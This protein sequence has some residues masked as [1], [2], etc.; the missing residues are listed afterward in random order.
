MS[1]SIDHPLASCSD[2]G[3]PD[4][5]GY[6]LSYEISRH[7]LSTSGPAPTNLFPT[8]VMLYLTELYST[9]GVA[10]DHAENC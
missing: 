9:A 2:I 6:L 4:Q 1:I 7:A 10:G 5:P 3:S 8:V